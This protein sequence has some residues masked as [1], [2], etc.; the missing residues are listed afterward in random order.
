MLVRLVL[1][2]AE[3]PWPWLDF[4]FLAITAGVIIPLVFYS[5]WPRTPE[6]RFLDDFLKSMRITA[7]FTLAMVVFFILFYAFVN[8]DFL[9]TRRTEILLKALESSP[10]AKHDSVREGVNSF[11]SLRNFSVLLLIGG[12][13]LCVFYSLLFSALKRLVIKSR[14]K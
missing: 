8:E 9:I 14:M 10:T 3:M 4:G 11:F 12:M 1:H 6:K 13:V 5:I 2:F 7:A